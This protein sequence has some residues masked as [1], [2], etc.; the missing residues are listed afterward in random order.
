MD[1]SARLMSPTGKNL[2][3]SNGTDFRN[4]AEV[5][6]PHESKR[7]ESRLG[8]SKSEM[9]LDKETYKFKPQALTAFLGVVFL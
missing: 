4:K 7:G 1:T 3:E 6:F 2:E 8:K 5:H 9:F